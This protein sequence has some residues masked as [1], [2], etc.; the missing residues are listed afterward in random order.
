MLDSPD[1]MVWRPRRGGITEGNSAMPRSIVSFAALVLVTSLGACVTPQSVEPPRV[2]LQNVRLLKSVGLVQFVQ[3]DLLVSNPND[4]DIPLTGMDFTMKVNGVDFAQGLSNATV[5]VPRLG[6]AT[7]PVE[8][9]IKMLTVFN[10][11]Q[12]V[13]KRGTLDYRLT[14]KAYLDHVLLPSVSF[15]RKGSLSLQRGGHGFQPVES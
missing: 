12:A 4:F 1:H 15:D 8:V 14:G 13:S 10:Q 7:V 3:V 6:R 5:T 2:Q 11:I 9:T